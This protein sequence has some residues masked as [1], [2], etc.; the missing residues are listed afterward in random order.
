VST[1]CRWCDDLPDV[2]ADMDCGGQR[3][4]VVWRRGKL[5]LADHDLL[6]E[7]TLMALGSEPPLC[8]ELL[9]A[10]RGLRGPQLLP[11]LLDRE[12]VPIEELAASRTRHAEAIEAATRF[13]AGEGQIL[14]G[15]LAG[16]QRDI[17]REK[18]A[19]ANTLLQALPFEFRHRLALA[20]I[21][22]VDR[23]WHDEEFRRAHGEHV[24]AVL[25]A[26]A[27]ACVERSA[28]CCR[29]DFAP[30]ARFFI[31]SRVLAPGESPGCSVR[32]DRRGATGTVSLPLDWFT[33]VWARQL[34]LVDESFVMRRAADDADA[35][36]AAVPVVALRWERDDE[37]VRR[38][39]EA[40]AVVTRDDEEARTLHWA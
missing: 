30:I 3:H 37:G 21:V 36:A 18:T 23:R 2:A 4:R 28:R 24:D 40:P 25:A 22:A 6:A 20:V 11:A 17:A 39:V 14:R 9:D 32:V 34:A 15:L 35:D 31:E 38:A 1:S 7:R 29:R 16:A 10:W 26:T 8:V 27:G 13:I 5:V 12:T 19:W 33:D